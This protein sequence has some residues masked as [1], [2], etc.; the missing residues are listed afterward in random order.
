MATGGMVMPKFNRDDIVKYY[1][2]LGLNPEEQGL[3]MKDSVNL[4][5]IGDLYELNEFDS[6]LSYTS[7][8]LSD[9]YSL[10]LAL[11]KDGFWYDNKKRRE[12]AFKSSFE[13]I[14]DLTKFDIEVK[15]NKEM[16]I[17]RM[18]NLKSTIIKGLCS[19]GDIIAFRLYQKNT[20]F[21]SIYKKIKDIENEETC[22]EKLNYDIEKTPID[23]MTLYYLIAYSKLKND[24]SDF[25]MFDGT[26]NLTLSRIRNLVK[27]KVSENVDTVECERENVE[28]S[29]ILRLSHFKKNNE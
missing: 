11:I 6:K 9:V 22:E 7:K 25:E 26:G 5:Y 3:I 12:N 21:K 18:N 19:A 29:K 15:Y 8:E 13:V 16:T 10:L 23:L 20:S 14:D 17:D 28:N 24:G 2:V 1:E 27:R 4:S